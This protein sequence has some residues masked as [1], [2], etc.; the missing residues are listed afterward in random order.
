MD[1][2]IPKLVRILHMAQI[3][4]AC[5]TCYCL[6][7]R[8]CTLLSRLIM[9]NMNTIRH[10]DCDCISHNKP[11]VNIIGIEIHSLLISYRMYQLLT[12]S[13]C[14]LK[15]GTV[16]VIWII[17]T[18]SGEF[19]SLNISLPNPL[20]MFSVSYNRLYRRDTSRATTTHRSI[21]YLRHYCCEYIFPIL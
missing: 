5:Q 15:R 13:Y 16:F 18:S 2:A 11:S 14:D 3:A 6:Q 20:H 4:V 1:N 17:S 21:N 7:L 9:H 19:D 10:L 12:S 8:N